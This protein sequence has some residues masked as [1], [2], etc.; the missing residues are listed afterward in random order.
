MSG[1]SEPTAQ[2]GRGAERALW[3][4]WCGSALRQSPGAGRPKQ[5]CGAGCRQAAYTARKLA[6]AAGLTSETVVV[7]RAGYEQLMSS[8]TSLRAAVADVE[9]VPP[10]PNDPADLQR[11][12]EWILSFARRI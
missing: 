5:Y 8:A 1:A 10:D 11:A 9:R 4:G 12:L 7:D 2:T 6:R 3:C